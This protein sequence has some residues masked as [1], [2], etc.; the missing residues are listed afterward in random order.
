MNNDAY[1]RAQALKDLASG[2]FREDVLTTNMGSW[3]IE[4]ESLKSTTDYRRGNPETL[5]YLEYKASHETI[6]HLSDEHPL[7]QVD[8]VKYPI[9]RMVLGALE[10]LPIVCPHPCLD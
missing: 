7:F 6:G 3:I 2:R 4:R 8:T 10:D 1:I 9:E 5:P